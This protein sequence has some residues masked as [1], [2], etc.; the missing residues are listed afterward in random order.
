MEALAVGLLRQLSTLGCLVALTSLPARSAVLIHDFALRGTLSDRLGGTSL[1]AMGG[2]ITALGYVTTLNQGLSLRSALLN[3]AD[4]TIAFS[5]GLSSSAG[6]MKLL[7]LHGMSD[8]TGLYQ[9]NG[10]LAFSPAASSSGASLRAG[11]NHVVLTRNGISGTVAGFLNGQQVFSF[12]DPSGV[13]VVAPGGVLNFFRELSSST[14]GGTL[15]TFTSIQ[16][17]N[18]ALT[19]TEVSNLY[20]MTVPLPVPEPSVVALLLT[21]LGAATLAFFRN[22]ERQRS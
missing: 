10:Q 17:Y 18:G 4:Y 9:H 2:Q 7:D 16:I 22:R 8:S 11:D 15:A 20:A 6:S 21:G 3:S 1:T 14:Q 5:F 12:A 19:S 13:A